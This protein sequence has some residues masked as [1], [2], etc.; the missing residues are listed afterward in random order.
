MK[1]I[2]YTD[3]AVIGH[4]L[5]LFN[6]KTGSTYTVT[7]WPDKD[8]SKKNIDAICCDANGNTLAIE[9]TLIEP[10]AGENADADRFLKTLGALEN[11][12]ALLQPGYMFVV[13]Q[14]V[15]SI[16][17]GIQWNEVPQEL[18]KQLP[19]LLPTVPELS[20]RSSP[21]V[22]QGANW[23][24][25]LRIQKSCIHSDGPGKFLTCRTFPGDPGYDLILRALKNK[26]PKLAKHSANKKI[27]LL[28]KDSIAGTI[29]SQFEKLPNTSE[30][31]ALLSSID[32]IW[33]VNTAALANNEDTI[34]TNQIWPTITNQI[35]P[36]IYYRAC[37]LNIKTGEYWTC[38]E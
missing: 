30:I 6:R 12:P 15:G 35:R 31:Q 26:T 14:P 24:L 18:L 11:H 20:G 32:E 4:W 2:R 23:K 22:I 1:T 36:T 38:S 19:R 9:H 17:T 29:E 8:S 27:L 34:F 10:F 7:D 21:V 33:S 37:S 16:P 28:E 25:D 3:K 5:Q 13:S